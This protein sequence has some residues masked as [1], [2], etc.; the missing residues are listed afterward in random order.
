MVRWLVA[1]IGDIVAKRVLAAIQAEPRSRLAGFLTRDPA[2]AERYG[3]RAWTDIH[4]ALAESDADAVYIATPVFL[5]APQTIASIKAGKHVLCEK[6]MA[7][8]YASAGEMVNAAADAGKLLG[9]A[10]YRRLYPKVARA[11]ELMEQGAIGQPVFVE[12]TA[13]DWFPSAPGFR[14]W[15]A[16]PAMAGGGPLRDVASHRIDLMN[17]LFG[18]PGRVCGQLS[19]MVQP[20]AVE[21]NA[22]V[23]VEYEKGVR[24]MVDARWHSHI[25]RDEFR[26]RGT[27]GE[28]DLT[29]LNGAAFVHPG[30]TEQI[31]PHANLHYPCI[32][33]FVDAVLEGA[34][35]VSSG[36]SALAAE[37]VMEQVA[38]TGVR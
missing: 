8:D 21:D 11:R 23:L 26:I 6:P 30:G 14:S 7:L 3:V 10:Y 17:Y 20:V 34:P 38:H 5:H 2:K 22:T 29:P 33:N 31:P 12:A 32:V 15:L 4:R 13:H 18:S 27:D 19:T 1:G 25:P 24:G 37:W 36:A 9:V 35:L 16:D 28:L